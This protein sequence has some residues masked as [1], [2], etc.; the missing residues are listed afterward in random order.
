VEEIQNVLT[1]V[2]FIDRGRI[3]FIAAMESSDRVIR[4]HGESEKIAAARALSDAR[5]PGTRPQ[6][7]VVD[8]KTIMPIVS[9]WRPWR[10]AYAK[11]RRLFV[12]M[13]GD[14][15]VIRPIAAQELPMTLIERHTRLR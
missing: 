8:L 6:R 11:H 10:R 15:P 7:P 2:M 5:A 4:S 9:N 1:D 12:A 14:N 3:V 13:L